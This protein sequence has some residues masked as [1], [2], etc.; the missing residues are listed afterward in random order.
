METFLFYF[1]GIGLLTTAGTAVV[2][3]NPMYSIISMIVSFFFIA[4]IYLILAAEFLAVVQIM[5]YA[6]AILV[7]FLSV[8]MLFDLQKSEYQKD[9]FNKFDIVSILLVGFGASKLI[10]LVVTSD[11][12]A[13]HDKARVIPQSFGTVKMLARDL[14]GAPGVLGRHTFVFEAISILLLAAIISA[15]VLA[16]KR[17]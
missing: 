3:K 5:V 6:G 1:F 17:L 13:N 8:I 16:K 11:S 12:V 9:K 2:L 15:V 7:L 4:G 10:A 14:F